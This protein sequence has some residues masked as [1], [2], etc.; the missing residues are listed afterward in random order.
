MTTIV[1]DKDKHFQNKNAKPVQTL[2]SVVT[3]CL[4]PCDICT[5]EYIDV[6]HSFRMRCCCRCHNNKV[7]REEVSH[8]IGDETAR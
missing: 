1:S 8:Q 4:A 6:T 2:P 3:V 7:D 5:Q